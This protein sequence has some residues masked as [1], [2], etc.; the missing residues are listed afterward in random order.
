[1][2]TKPN[3]KGVA[4]SKVGVKKFFC[5]CKNKFGL[6]LQGVCDVKG[7]YLDVTIGYPDSTLD[8]FA[9]VTSKLHTKLETPGFL[10]L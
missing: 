7:R 3:I 5:R 10:A 1:M 9:F 4:V 8:Y 6:N 2:H